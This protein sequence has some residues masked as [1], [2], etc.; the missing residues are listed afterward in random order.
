MATQIDAAAVLTQEETQLEVEEST[1]EA[2]EL[3]TIQ[4]R[5]AELESL[6][7]KLQN[8]LKSRDGQRRKQ[9]EDQNLLLDMQDEIKGQRKL[10]A[11][12]LDSLQTGDTDGLAE[13][14]VAMEQESSAGQVSRRFQA[15]YETATQKLLSAVNDDDGN[16]S[17]TEEQS[18]AVQASWKAAGEEA[19]R[20]GDFSGLNDVIVD[21]AKTVTR[22][23]REAKAQEENRIKEEAK[24]T[25]KKR[26]EKAGVNDLDT[27]PS[28]GGGGV[29]SWAQA[30]KIKRVSD[31]SDAA[32]EKLRDSG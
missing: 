9:A 2:L 7:L 28:A 11:L 12:Y 21:A 14:R 4:A 5:V 16:L 30:Q 3:A 32:Y 19:F 6:N 31:L 18:V 29:M 26:L 27:G 24:A 1:K 20:T 13:K 15:R 17:L 25:T 10:V 23:V 22:N 8:D